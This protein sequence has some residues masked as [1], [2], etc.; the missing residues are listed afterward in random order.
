MRNMDDKSE[1]YLEQSLKSMV[2]SYT[3]KKGRAK[4]K[5]TFDNLSIKYQNYQHHKL[6]IT[7]NPLEYGKLIR[8]IDNQFFV[9]VNKTNIA[10]IT[11]EDNKNI[12]KFFKEGDLTYE[13]S[14][15]KVNESTFVRYLENK[16][17]TFRN[18]KLILLAIEKTVNFIKPLR[19]LQQLTNK[20]ITLDIE[21]FIQDG[22]HIPY[23][24]S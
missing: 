6:P 1:Y 11:Q 18:K 5:V 23:A 3:I 4:D 20:I 16:K 24:I 12:I 2:F 10:I 14:D 17:F 22:M 15:Y 21:T 19:Q 13:F 9:Q 7:M 8:K